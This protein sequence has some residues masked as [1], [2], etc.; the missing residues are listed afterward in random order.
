MNDAQ[1]GPEAPPQTFDPNDGRLFVTLPTWP[2]PVGILSI[3]F[4]GL[5]VLCGGIGMAML[6]FQARLSA[7]LLEGAPPPPHMVFSAVE[8]VLFGASLLTNVLLV[9]AGILLLNR[10]PVSRVLHIVYAV[11][12]LGV[13]LPSVAIQLGKIGKIGAWVAA[14]P[15]NPM[16]Q[17]MQGPGQEQLQAIGPI[18][19]AVLGVCWPL[20]CLIWFGLIKTKA[21]QYT[22]Q[23]G[24]ADDRTA[25]RP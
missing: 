6:P 2:K 1:N 16:A 7:P 9:A 15:D 19:Q 4:G 3:V 8:Y 10:R 17:S 11:V 5:S 24:D 22:G 20:F 12:F 18:V 25:V 13:L 21:V 14:H 23:G